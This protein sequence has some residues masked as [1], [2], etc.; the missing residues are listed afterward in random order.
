MMLSKV[1]QGRLHRGLTELEIF[2]AH[3]NLRRMCPKLTLLGINTK[4]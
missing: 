3:Y 1:T 4:Q 2:F